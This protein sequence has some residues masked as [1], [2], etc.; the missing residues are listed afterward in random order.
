[1]VLDHD[2]NKTIFKYIS[3]IELD[4][5]FYLIFKWTMKKILSIFMML[6]ILL[7]CGTDNIIE[8]ESEKNQETQE[9][10][11]NESS[12]T[13][14]WAIENKTV[15]EIENELITKKKE[16]LTVISNELILEKT[17]LL[18]EIRKGETLKKQQELKTIS[19]LTEEEKKEELNIFLKEL[20]IKLQKSLEEYKVEVMHVEQATLEKIINSLPKK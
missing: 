9:T 4:N 3:K 7:S 5:I 14:I 1:M 8:T 13:W 20:E 11:E 16:Y 17:L 18:D 19:H 12:N 6:F 15:E 2:V 10:Q